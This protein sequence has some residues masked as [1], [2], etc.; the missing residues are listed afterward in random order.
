MYAYVF[1]CMWFP[2]ECMPGIRA[3]QNVDTSMHARVS[4]PYDMSGY[5]CIYIV[6]VV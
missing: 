4:V 6:F 5:M 1:D 3:V 2:Q